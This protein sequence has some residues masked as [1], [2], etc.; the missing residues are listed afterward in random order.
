MIKNLVKKLSLLKYFLYFSSFIFVS[1]FL[2]LFYQ[3]KS[4][5]LLQ[6]FLPYEFDQKH[7]LDLFRQYI[8]S[9]FGVSVLIQCCVYVFIHYIWKHA[10][11]LF[12]Q[13]REK[14]EEL[15]HKILSVTTRREEENHYVKNLKNWGSQTLQNNHDSEMAMN[16]CVQQIRKLKE[17][18]LTLWEARET[19]LKHFEE[20]FQQQQET[21]DFSFVLKRFVHFMEEIKHFTDRIE[22]RHSLLVRE[23]LKKG[24]ELGE[25]QSLTILKDILIDK[26]YFNNTVDQY[27][28]TL[29]KDVVC[30]QDD[31]RNRFYLMAGELKKMLDDDY[32]FYQQL[33][34]ILTKWDKES[35][36]L[37]AN[38]TSFLFAEQQDDSSDDLIPRYQ[39]LLQ[40]LNQVT[41]QLLSKED[42]LFSLSSSFQSTTHPVS[43]LMTESALLRGKET[44]E[45]PGASL[46]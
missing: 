18:Q 16:F 19:M 28:T 37:S 7:L 39:E 15:K 43:H 41:N 17:D 33:E 42:S 30:D 45:T 5:L 13:G 24:L 40:D 38:K 1:C 9:F 36:R 34:E 4:L 44:L 31:K 32:D 11:S 20:E 35:H 2:L 46:T 3:E 25:S 21:Q 23:E 6:F 22:S 14:T 26:T 10:F 27:R 8:L 29:Q 12:H